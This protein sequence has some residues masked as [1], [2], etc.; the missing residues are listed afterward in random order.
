[1]TATAPETDRVA[2]LH[3]LADPDA[4][5]S[6]QVELLVLRAA[7][8]AGV[9]M[10]SLNLIDTDRQC[11]VATAGHTGRPTPRADAMCSVTLEL[12]TAVVV[13]DARQD[14]RFADSPW[15][16]GRL[17][18]VRFYASAP[19]TTRR[20]H[21]VGTLCVFDIEPHVLTARQVAD[22]VALAEH[23]VETL[24]HEAAARA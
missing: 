4:A 22:L 9:P 23:V 15:V 11:P 6:E 13:A 21:V 18:A 10:A 16:D 5:S 14:P 24:E 3:A 20:G 1:V 17:G 2:D 7:Q 19:L 8:I 12:G